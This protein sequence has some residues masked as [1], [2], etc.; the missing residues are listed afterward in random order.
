MNVFVNYNM[1]LI[2]ELHNKLKIN[3]Q[4]LYILFKLLANDEDKLLK[5]IMKNVRTF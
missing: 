1:T 2:T 5:N 4:A 3:N